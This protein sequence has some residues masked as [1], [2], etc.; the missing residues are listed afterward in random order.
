[1]NKNSGYILATKTLRTKRI[2][3]IINHKTRIKRINNTFYEHSH[4]CKRRVRMMLREKEGDTHLLDSSP[5]LIT[6][7]CGEEQ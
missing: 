3:R 5:T 4:E 1:M 6:Q 7:R 2:V